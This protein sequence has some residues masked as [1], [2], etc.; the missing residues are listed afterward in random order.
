MSARLA[1]RLISY[2]AQSRTEDTAISN[3]L[4]HYADNSSKYEP[5]QCVQ[6]VN[7]ISAKC[8]PFFWHTKDYTFDLNYTP[9]ENELKKLYSQIEYNFSYINLPYK[10]DLGNLIISILLS[11]IKMALRKFVL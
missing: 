5:M 2:V 10:A 9:Y 4:Q 6:L 11:K 1:R 3:A 8:D 7:D